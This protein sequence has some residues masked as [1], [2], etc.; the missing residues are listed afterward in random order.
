[1]LIYNRTYLTN[2]Q[3]PGDV[4]G[5]FNL[6]VTG[7]DEFVSSNSSTSGNFQ[8]VLNPNIN[9]AICQ[10]LT[11]PNELDEPVQARIPVNFS[12]N[13]PVGF[14]GSSVQVNISYGTRFVSGSNCN[15]TVINA[16]NRD[17]NCSMPMSFYY[18]PGAYTGNI[19]FADPTH[20]V[21]VNISG[22]CSYA[23]LLATHRY[24]S[25]VT[26]GIV[27]PGIQNLSSNVPV[28]FRNTGNVPVNVSLKA[29]DL[30]G[31]RISSAHLVASAFRA[32]QYLPS[33]AVLQD[34]TEIPLNITMVPGNNSNVSFWLWLTMP[35]S[36]VDEQSY[37]SQTFWEVIGS[38]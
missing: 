7:Q 9:D 38:G 8:I 10:A 19:S 22:S 28:V 5:Q 35:M 33:S 3:F 36:I 34:G 4:E 18:A 15:Y 24:T 25:G 13:A 31:E 21:L 1:M 17:Y 11:Y 32:G 37:Y 6:R 2:L 27:T 29:Y 12:V 20:V 30:V 26:F 16:Q 14:N 23:S